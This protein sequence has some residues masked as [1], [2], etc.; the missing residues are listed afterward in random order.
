MALPMHT[1]VC[2]SAHPRSQTIA[3]IRSVSSA[4]MSSRAHV[5]S[6]GNELM[7][8]VCSVSSAGMKLLCAWGVPQRKVSGVTFGWASEGGRW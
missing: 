3:Y 5:P 6:E 7:P 4:H 2:P 1:D 8:T